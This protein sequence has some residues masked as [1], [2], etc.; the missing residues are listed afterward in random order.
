MRWWLRGYRRARG[1]SASSDRQIEAVVQ[2][3]DELIQTRVR[4]RT[5]TS[6]IARRIRP[7]A[8]GLDHRRA[9]VRGHLERCADLP[10]SLDGKA[11]TSDWAMRSDAAALVLGPDSGPTRMTVSPATP[12]AACSWRIRRPGPHAESPRKS[13]ALRRS[14]AHGRAQQRRLGGDVVDRPG[15]G[16]TARL[17]SESE[18]GHDRL[19]GGLCIPA[20]QARPAARRR[21]SRVSDRS[22]MRT[23]RR[24]LPSPRGAT[25][26][27]WR[28]PSRAGSA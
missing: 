13:T 25:R 17:V 19:G 4:R 11:I 14:S 16:P 7:A 28:A 22:L 10:C 3:L 20:P 5:D 15:H 26:V 27:T 6:S 21:R 8:R 12:G 24:V 1:G 9:V 23:A 18:R 2:S